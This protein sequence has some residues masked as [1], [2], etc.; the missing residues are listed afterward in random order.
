[1]A[2][3]VRRAVE[4]AAQLAVEKPDAALLR[5]LEEAAGFRDGRLIPES[6]VVAGTNQDIINAWQTVLATRGAAL[7]GA[8]QADACRF[9]EQ[10]CLDWGKVRGL[11]DFPSLL[12]TLRRQG[13]VLGGAGGCHIGQ[14]RAHSALS[15]TSW[16]RRLF[17]P[18]FQR[19]PCLPP[20]A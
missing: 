8:E 13:L 2:G 5:R 17:C 14:L 16:Y 9:L 4:H 3:A 19:R 10:A 15:E 20:Q 1:M 12:D 6:P 11:A 18:H 7:R